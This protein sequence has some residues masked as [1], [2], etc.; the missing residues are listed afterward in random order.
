PARR[1]PDPARLLQ[2]LLRRSGARSFLL[3]VT[4]PAPDA[5]PGAPLACLLAEDTR[6]EAALPPE[7][8]PVDQVGSRVDWPRLLAQYAALACRLSGFPVTFDLTT[9][10]GRLTIRWNAFPLFL[11]NPG[12][13]N[14]RVDT[15]GCRQGGGGRSGCGGGVCLGGR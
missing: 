7:G 4:L 1:C 14:G 6:P 13:R 2:V 9:V 5:R 12:G 3:G 11:P 10:P 15:P 8:P